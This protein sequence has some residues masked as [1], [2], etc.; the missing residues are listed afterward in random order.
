MNK[1]SLTSA[2]SQIWALVN[3][4]T[5]ETLTSAHESELSAAIGSLESEW[6][7]SDI[8]AGRA[9]H[10]AM[11]ARMLLAALNSHPPRRPSGRRMLIEDCQFLLHYLAPK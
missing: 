9:A 4:S 8:Y 6:D 3:R 11:C 7:D 1:N 2:L 10:V 5:Q